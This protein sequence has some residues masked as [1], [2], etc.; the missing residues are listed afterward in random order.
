MRMCKEAT[1]LHPDLKAGLG[2][3][4]ECIEICF[5]CSCRR[6][7]NCFIYIFK[8]TY[9]PKVNNELA[10]ETTYQVEVALVGRSQPVRS[11][12]LWNR[13]H[14]ASSRTLGAHAYVQPYMSMHETLGRLPINEQRHRYVRMG[15][16]MHTHV[17]YMYMYN[18]TGIWRPSYSYFSHNALILSSVLA[19]FWVQAQL[20]PL[21]WPTA[22]R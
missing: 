13:V 21:Y 9:E 22:H 10:H 2:T 8:P 20:T 14:S 4:V 18:G 16:F 6:L 11:G 5:T 19:W 1:V 7:I 17:V 15:E 12:L 3:R